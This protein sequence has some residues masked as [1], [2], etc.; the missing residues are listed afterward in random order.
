MI[1]VRWRAGVYEHPPTLH[2]QFP[3]VVRMCLS[4]SRVVVAVALPMF[5]VPIRQSYFSITTVD[6][7]YVC[8]SLVVSW[9]AWSVSSL[10]VSRMYSDQVPPLN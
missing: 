9:C 8:R 6:S 1:V 10:N 3:T 2:R 5:I 4:D 7:H